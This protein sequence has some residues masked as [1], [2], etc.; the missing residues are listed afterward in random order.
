MYMEYN[1]NIYLDSDNEEDDV[2]TTVTPNVSLTWKRPRLD[3]SLSARLSMVKYL[4]HTDEDRIGA[5][6]NQAASLNA[7]ARLYRELFFL[8]VTDTYSRVPVDE[9]GRGGE[10]NTTI[11][12]TDSNTLQDQSLPAVSS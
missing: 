6:T 5:D 12:L 11:N 3:L 4:D 8:R 1:D 10:S 7:L 2:I 9:G